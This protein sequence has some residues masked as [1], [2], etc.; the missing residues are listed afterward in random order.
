MEDNKEIVD[1]LIV[2]DNGPK[3]PSRMFQDLKET[4]K[5]LKPLPLIV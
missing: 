3:K 2:S 5:P 1:S 4:D